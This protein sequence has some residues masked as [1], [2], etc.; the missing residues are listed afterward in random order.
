MVQSALVR[1]HA[2][3]LF[4][5][6]QAYTAI[7]ECGSDFVHRLCSCVSRPRLG[8]PQLAVFS[9]HMEVPCYLYTEKKH[10][11]NPLPPVK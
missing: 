1:S 2:F 4:A 9:V 7:N 8:N 10:C 3:Y 11:L 6:F 5:L